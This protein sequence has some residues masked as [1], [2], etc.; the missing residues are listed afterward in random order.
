MYS[1]TFQLAVHML[2]SIFLAIK[3]TSATYI[4]KVDDQIND[5][6]HSGDKASLHSDCNTIVSDSFPIRKKRHKLRIMRSTIRSDCLKPV[7]WWRCSSRWDKKCS[8]RYST[9]TLIII[10]KSRGYRWNHLQI[11]NQC[12]CND[13]INWCCDYKPENDGNLE[14]DLRDNVTG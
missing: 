9:R 13:N 7:F 6:K 10:N 14:Q 5:G 8:V 4:C 2:T 1:L 3:K 12:R 11:P